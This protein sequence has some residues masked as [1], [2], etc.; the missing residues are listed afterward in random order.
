MAVGR[1]ISYDQKKVRIKLTEKV[2]TGDQLEFWVKIGGRVTATLEKFSL[3][4]NVLTFELDKKVQSG[5]R[6]FKIFDSELNAH[7]EKIIAT[8]RKIPC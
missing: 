5:D 7:A 2:S 4:D 6:V 1:V 3:R 8:E